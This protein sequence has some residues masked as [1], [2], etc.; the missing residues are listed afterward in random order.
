MKSSDSAPSSKKSAFVDH[1]REF[2]GAYDKEVFQILGWA[3][4]P[5]LAASIFWIGLGWIGRVLLLSNT[6]VVGIWIDSL[7]AR[8]TPPAFF[9]GW[10]ASNYFD[11]LLGLCL[12]GLLLTLMFRIAFSRLSVRAISSIYDEVT[13]RVSRYPVRFFDR[14]P[15]GRIVTRFS[16]DYGNMFRMFGGPLSEFFGIVF[17]LT[18]SLVLL[19]A[20]HKL[21]LIFYFVLLALNVLIY[22]SN[23]KKIR[24]ARRDQ[25]HRRSPGIAHFA[26]TVQGASV[27]RVFGKQRHFFDRFTQLDNQYIDAKFRAIRLNVLYAAQM[28]SSTY[29]IAFLSGLAGLLLISR[30]LMSPGEVAAVLVILSLAGTSFQMF[31]DWMIQL[32]DAFVGVE[33]MNEYL[34]LPLEPEAV[35]PKQAVFPFGLSTTPTPTQE[36]TDHQMLE[37]IELEINNL[38]FRYEK[39]L[40]WILRDLS[41]KIEKGEKVGIVGRTGAGKT[42]VFQVLQGFYPY[43]SGKI[44]FGGQERSIADARRLMAVV[45][46][47][48]VLFN[49]TVRQNLALDEGFDDAHLCEILDRVGLS[50]WT[51]RF[52]SP[53]DFVIEE[54]GKNLSQGEKQLLVMA[55]MSLVRCPLVLMDEATS[56]ID[57]KTEEH[58]VKAMH[59]IFKGRTQLIIAHRLSTIESCDRVLWLKDGKVELFDKPDVVL[60]RFQQQDFQSEIGV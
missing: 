55:R 38:Q 53:L 24:L 39:D 19:L 31:F 50:A 25:S 14:T 16:S 49:D 27:I 26:E 1:E 29:G 11:L 23:K 21:G 41:F 43:E 17:D 20:V 60:S 10:T 54:K 8:S 44:L 35:L 22:T 48:P 5:Y 51:Q 34:R 40:P 33:R 30:G 56:S 36:P 47:D 42:S 45:P 18:A 59:L 2:R 9:E 4:K 7:S 15:V 13:L 28:M 32:E 3:Y 12:S 58:L 46:Q 52:S 37:A 6:L 57:P